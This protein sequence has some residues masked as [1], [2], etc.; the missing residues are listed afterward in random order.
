MSEELKMN[1]YNINEIFL[2]TDGK[3]YQCVRAEA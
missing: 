3:V 1:E 2:H